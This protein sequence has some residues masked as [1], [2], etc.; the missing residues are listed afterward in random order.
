MTDDLGYINGSLPGSE[1]L[2]AMPDAVQSAKTA[3]AKSPLRTTMFKD[4]GM[5]QRKIWL[6]DNFLGAGEESCVYGPPGVAKSILVTDLACHVAAG[7]DWFGRRVLHGSVLYVAAERAKLVERRLAAFRRHYNLHDLPLALVSGPTD[8]RTNAQHAGIIKKFAEELKAK[9]GFPV[10]LIIIDTVSRVLNGGDENSPRDMGALISNISHLQEKTGAHVMVV[11]H[12]PQ[13]GNVRLRG[14]GSLLGALDTTIA[15]EKAGSLRSATIIKSNDGADDQRITF[16]LQSV[17]LTTDEE[18]GQDTTAPIV[19]PLD[20]A[21]SKPA[22]KKKLTDRQKNAMTALFDLSVN[23][24][25]PP[26]SL[27]LPT[28]IRVLDVTE[29]REELLSRRVLDPEGANPRA[30]FFGALWTIF[31]EYSF[32]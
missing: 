2:E 6:A 3:H 24:K 13:D 16:D 32:K 20:G 14:H 21:A 10:V 19:V 18:T 4:I 9:T 11:H 22:P 28:G 12:I 26:T 23:G 17:I 30:A 31:S 29:W 7:R 15:V 5:E 1:P 27:G 25:A 8:L